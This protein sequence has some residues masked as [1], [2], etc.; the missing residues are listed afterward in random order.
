M[1]WKH[2]AATVAVVMLVS[3]ATPVATTALYGLFLPSS[4][5]DL[6]R[7]VIPASA[8]FVVYLGAVAAPSVA[9]I[10]V[11][12]YRRRVFW[13]PPGPTAGV[14]MQAKATVVVLAVWALVL[15]WTVGLAPTFMA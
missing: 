11:I 10:A 3:V 2:V 4:S 6:E 9:A 13:E 5:T 15:V 7:N 14:S 8:F 1:A 12:L